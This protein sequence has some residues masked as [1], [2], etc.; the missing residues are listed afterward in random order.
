MFL[1]IAKNEI[2]Q[3]KRSKKHISQ[4]L[5]FILVPQLHKITPSFIYYIV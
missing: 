5:K 4:A 1:P 3:F 2:F